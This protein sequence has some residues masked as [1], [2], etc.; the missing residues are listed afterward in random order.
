MKTSF[1]Q[2][3]TNPAASERGTGQM[4]RVEQS[5]SEVVLAFC[6]ERIFDTFH[7]DDLLAYVKARVTIAPDS[8]GRI[9]RELRANG[10]VD[11]D[12]VSRARSE[13]VIRRVD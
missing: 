13:Y 4:K 5:I 2:G 3:R 11:Y 10:R 7:M 12:V 6:R 1:E 8:A 9:L